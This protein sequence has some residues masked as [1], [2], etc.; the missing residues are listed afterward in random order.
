VDITADKRFLASAAWLSPGIRFCVWSL[1][2]KQLIHESFHL[3][4]EVN[5]TDQRRLD[6]DVEC[7]SA[8]QEQF[9]FNVGKQLFVFDILTNLINTVDLGRVDN[10]ERLQLLSAHTRRGTAYADCLFFS[11]N[12]NSYEAISLD[13]TAAIPAPRKVSP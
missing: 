12:G 2:T 9:V 4:A 10:L 13:S 6:F 7:V 11:S 3:K 8:S 5:P 1:D